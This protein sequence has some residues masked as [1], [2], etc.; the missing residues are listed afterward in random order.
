MGG[1]RMN[2]QNVF[3]K[4]K[5]QSIYYLMENDELG[6]T[7]E[8]TNE[9]RLSMIEAEQL[10]KDRGIDFQE[11]LKVRY[12]DVEIEIPIHDLNSYIIKK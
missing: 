5:I 1:G 7:Y 2:V 8:S 10:L 6:I 12:E 4:T 3:L 9:K 11:V